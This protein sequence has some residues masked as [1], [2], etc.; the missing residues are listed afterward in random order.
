[1]M[2]NVHFLQNTCAEIKIRAERRAGELLKEQ[3]P[4]EGGR[5]EKKQL[6]NATVSQKPKLEDL[7]IEKT[8]SHRWQLMADIPEDKFEQHIA[9]TK[10]KKAEDSGYSRG[11]NEGGTMARPFL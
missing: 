4:H 10:E 6:Q 2:G 5:P 11:K 8:Q 7:G 9:E 1:M 3:I